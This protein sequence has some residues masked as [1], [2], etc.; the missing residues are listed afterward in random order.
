MAEAREFDIV[1]FGA[2]GFVGKLICEYLVEHAPPTA[3]I[4]LAGRSA[5]KLA[6]LVD[7]LG[8]VA[9]EWGVI[10]ADS[11][12]VASLDAMTT[13]TRVLLT[14]V[15]PY[16]KYGHEVAASCARNGTHSVDL[17]GE[18]LFVLYCA[19]EL[20]EIA[21]E[22]GA[23]IVNSCGFDSIPG[24][25]AVWLAAQEAQRHDLGELTD[26][27]LVVRSMKGGL[28]GGTIDS[29]RVQLDKLKANPALR[30][31]VAD[32]YALSPDRAAEPKTKQPTDTPKPRHDAQLGGWVAPFIMAPF[33]TRFIRRTNALL[34]WE[35]G[36]EFRY[37][38][39]CCFPDNPRGAAMAYAM[40]AGLAATMYG[41]S[42]GPSRIVFD[43][44]LPKPGQG[45]SKESRENGRFRMEV[46]AQTSRGG[47]VSSTVAAKGDPG[48]AATSIMISEA[49]LALAFDETPDR[50]GVL[51][52]VTGIGAPLIERLRAAGF[53]ASAEL[54]RR[55]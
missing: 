30:K 2:T 44:L 36:R 4:A 27:T 12:D 34:D 23:K 6:A 9:R 19:N 7:G 17:T 39:I 28:S 3:R 49:A 54:V 47:E 10:E 8:P 20:D 48:Y 31:K 43:R 55:V 18:P 15:G 1:V 51:T 40:T 22:S 24:D 53:T 29:L 11:F 46:Q 21:K 32:W 13:R 42:F 37:Q 26:V 50:A 41:M 16:E 5:T 25:F 35:Y 52:P 14:T 33:N 38:E 45:P